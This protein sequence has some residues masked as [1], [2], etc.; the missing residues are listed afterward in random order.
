MKNLR[1]GATHFDA[2]MKLLR[3]PLTGLQMARVLV[4]FPLMTLQVVAGIYYQALRLWLKRIPFFDHPA[5]LAHGGER[6][7][8][9]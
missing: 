1:G 7:P 2:T 5:S 8:T 4:A 9:I 6:P 3:R